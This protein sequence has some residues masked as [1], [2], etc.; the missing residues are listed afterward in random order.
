VEYLFEILR[1]RPEWGV[2]QKCKRGRQRIAD[3]SGVVEGALVEKVWVLELAAS[4]LN[5]RVFLSMQINMT[6]KLNQKAL[7]SLL[8]LAPSTFARITLSFAIR[9][10]R[11]CSKNIRSV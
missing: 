9:Y 10:Y 8:N 6:N 3:F 5:A 2:Q 4:K 11:L 1:G 7:N